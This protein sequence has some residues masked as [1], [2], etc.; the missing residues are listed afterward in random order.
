MLVFYC[1]L[2]FK[3]GHPQRGGGG[4]G[5][6]QTTGREGPKQVI[7]VDILCRWPLKSTQ[8]LY[9]W[10]V[11]HICSVTALEILTEGCYFVTVLLRNYTDA[12]LESTVQN[13]YSSHNTMLIKTALKLDEADYGR[14]NQ[15]R[16]KKRINCAWLVVQCLKIAVTK[17]TVCL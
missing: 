2:A 9:W 3:C 17:C 7:C 14:W 1:S 4:Q 10:L 16:L 5:Q 6:M 13:F 15:V 8:G 11:L 12:F